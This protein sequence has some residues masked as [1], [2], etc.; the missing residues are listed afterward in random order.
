MDLQHIGVKI[1]ARPG[2][3]LDLGPFIGLFHRWIQQQALPGLL[4]LDVA[5]YQHVHEGPGVMLICHEGHFAMD[6]EGGRLGLLYTNKRL[7]TGDPSQRFRTA[8]ERTL[9][10]ARRLEQDPALEGG[11]TFAGDELLIKVDDHLFVQH[12]ADAFE[13]VRGELEP[14]LAGLGGGK[15]PALQRIEDRGGGLVLSARLGASAGTAELL[16]RVRAL[17]SS[18]AGR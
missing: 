18:A 7:A 1:F 12:E 6:Q 5:D 9:I 14:V 16:D 2:Q 15:A 17:D 4:M 11:L 8:I 3:G 10:A 13:S